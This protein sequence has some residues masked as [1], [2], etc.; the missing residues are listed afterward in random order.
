MPLVQTPNAR[1]KN[2]I[3]AT[4]EGK[5][6]LYHCYCRVRTVVNKEETR[7]DCLCLRFC[8]IAHSILQYKQ[9]RFWP[10]NALTGYNDDDN[11]AQEKT[12][13]QNIES[14]TDRITVQKEFWRQTWRILINY[15]MHV[16]A[17][18]I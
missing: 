5:R 17:G 4:K 8:S 11:D 13:Q 1:M 3:E 18:Q 14:V 7:Y 16:K 15:S 10:N 12:S 2:L 9:H 6:L